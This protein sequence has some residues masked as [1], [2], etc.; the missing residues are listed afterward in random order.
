MTDSFTGGC[1]RG[2]I[3]YRFTG[4]ARYMGN[5]HCR[6]CQQ[7]T[8]GAYFPAVLVKQSDFNIEMG[9][10]S[11]FQR[12]ADRGHAIRRGFCATCGSPL[13]M[14]NCLATRQYCAVPVNWDRV[15]GSS[16]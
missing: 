11:W 9:K 1:A 5:C 15:A 14:T 8:G 12:P 13:V 10:P 7:A 6:H 4:P 2:A 16:V 3:R